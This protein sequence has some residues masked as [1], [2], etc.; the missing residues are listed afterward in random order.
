MKTFDVTRTLYKVSDFLGWQK[1][2]T[3]VL[4]PS[5]QRRSVWNKGAKSYLIDTIVR[6]LPIPILFLRERRTDLKSFEPT[7]ELVDGQQRIRTLI[8]FIL[9]ELLDDLSEERDIFTMLRSH[10]KENAGKSFEKLPTNIKERILDYQFSVHILPTG[11]DDR[12]VLQIFSRMNSTGT[13]LNNQELRNAEF[14]GEFKTSMHEIAYK[15]LNRWRSWKI[16]TES[17]ISRMAEVELSSELSIF[18][19]HGTSAKKRSAIDKIFKDND[20]DFP[21]RAE[22]ERRFEKVM[23]SID[24]CLGYD[25]PILPYKNKTLFY[26]LFAIMYELL[27]DNCE[28]TKRKKANTIT[29]SNINDLNTFAEK[30]NEK[31]IEPEL[32]ESFTRRTTDA[33]SRGILL[34]HFRKAVKIDAN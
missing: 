15:Q 33:S 4:S 25:I 1:A 2:G 8:S 22:I 11:T 26:G 9:P 14:Y 21:E 23:D 34:K 28:L 13:K 12:E 7:R 17:N 18:M 19:L 20:I 3:L 24:D 10:N 32:L 6:G 27:F 30:I 16:F 31:D 5:F 29:Q